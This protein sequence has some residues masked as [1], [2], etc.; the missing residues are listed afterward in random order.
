MNPV[1][2]LKIDEKLWIDIF[3]PKWSGNLAPQGPFLTRTLKSTH[4]ILVSWSHIKDW[5]NGHPPPPIPIFTDFLVIKDPL[6][7][8]VENLILLAH[9]FCNIVVQSEGKYRKDRMKTE[10]PCSNWKKKVKGKGNPAFI[11][12]TIEYIH[13]W[14]IVV[15]HASFIYQ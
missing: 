14:Y 5:E 12:R 3:W 4:N 6:K 1:E 15:I 10:G 11:C 7:L 13:Q 9:F 8:E 2:A